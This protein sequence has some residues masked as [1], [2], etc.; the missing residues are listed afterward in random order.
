VISHA[1]DWKSPVGGDRHGRE[2]WPH[3]MVDADVDQLESA[4]LAPELDPRL[5]R[6]SATAREEKQ[7]SIAKSGSTRR[8]H[9]R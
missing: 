2:T 1:P 3:R 4:C 8:G 5:R 6:K 7:N 9:G